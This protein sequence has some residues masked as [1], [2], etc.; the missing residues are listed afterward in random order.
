M[1]TRTIRVLLRGGQANSATW[2]RGDGPSLVG[3]NREAP[4]QGQG[5]SGSPSRGALDR[6]APAARDLLRHMRQAEIS[7]DVLRWRRYISLAQANARWPA[8]DVRKL[9]NGSGHGPG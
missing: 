3:L 9:A 4:R 5:G 1:A 6:R 7:A 2:T 8:T